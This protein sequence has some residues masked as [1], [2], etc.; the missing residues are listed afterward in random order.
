MDRICG[1]C[2]HNMVVHRECGQDVLRPCA[3][4]VNVCG[5]DMWAEDHYG[6][7]VHMCAFRMTELCVHTSAIL[8]VV[9]FVLLS[10]HQQSHGGSNPIYLP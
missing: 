4:D 3:Y 9:L 2:V 8:N 1:D 10:P 5:Q 7:G 6:R